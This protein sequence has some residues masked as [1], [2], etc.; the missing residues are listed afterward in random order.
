MNQR[1]RALFI[2]I[3]SVVS[4]LGVV[5]GSLQLINGFSLSVMA[6]LMSA[7]PMTIFLLKLFLTDVARTS[8]FLPMFSMVVMGA[9]FILI[10]NLSIG[11]NFEWLEVLTIICLV[12]WGLYIFWYSVFPDRYT[13]KLA[14]GQQL[15]NFPLEATS[16][17][18]VTSRTFLGAR[19]IFLFYRGNWCPLCTTQIKELSE[20]YKSLEA[21][22][23]QTHLISPQSHK[24]TQSIADKYDVGFNYWIDKDNTAAKALGIFAKNGLPFGLQ[25][26]GYESDTVLPTVI[27]TDE[28]GKIVY[29]DQTSN[30]RV[31]PEPAVFLEIFSNY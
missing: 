23:I 9:L 6:L 20:A 27:M 11:G 12:G 1:P 5:L 26:L 8:R 16:G 14:V 15:I 2:G 17:Q 7:A 24:Q 4:L 13:E 22:K 28:K 19:N 29:A 21:Q 10:Y 3:Y 18:E 25:A 31:R 30:Y